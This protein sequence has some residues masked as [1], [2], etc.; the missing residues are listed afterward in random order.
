MAIYLCAGVVIILYCISKELYEVGRG[1][2]HVTNRVG[3]G[4][5]VGYTRVQLR[6]VATVV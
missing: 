6:Y 3:T 1:R 4:G 5:V 2:S